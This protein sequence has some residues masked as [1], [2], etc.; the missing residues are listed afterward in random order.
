M[1]DASKLL[2]A[3]QRRSARQ[4]QQAGATITPPNRKRRR[5]ESCV[6]GLPTR[7][8][9]FA[10][11]CRCTTLA[12][13]APFRPPRRACR[14]VRRQPLEP[15]PTP[16]RPDPLGWN[17][18]ARRTATSVPRPRYPNKKYSLFQ[19]RI[20]WLDDDNL[21]FGVHFR[22]AKSALTRL[23]RFRRRAAKKLTIIIPLEMGLSS[24]AGQSHNDRPA[25]SATNPPLT[26]N[27]WVSVL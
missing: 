25:A 1:P 19:I 15:Y 12:C 13:P 3:G 2:H 5:P 14:L 24:P 21:K 26:P 9:Q 17:V 20:I 27:C 4:C 10:R 8:R 23:A 7:I 18:A 6:G 11:P 22:R 16:P